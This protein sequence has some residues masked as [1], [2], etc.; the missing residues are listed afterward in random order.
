MRAL[1]T[2]DLEHCAGGDVYVFGY[3]Y[4]S[5]G[6]FDYNSYTNAGYDA[7]NIGAFPETRPPESEYPNP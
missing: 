4:S 5:Y 6:G 3:R 7:S 2:T 1:T